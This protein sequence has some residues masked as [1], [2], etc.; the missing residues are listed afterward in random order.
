VATR[1]RSEPPQALPLEVEL[2]PLEVE[3]LRLEEEQ[4]LGRGS[5]R[6]R[7]IPPTRPG[8]PSRRARAGAQR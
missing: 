2:R 8:P 5:E 7:P 3:L 4:A 6:I 1:R